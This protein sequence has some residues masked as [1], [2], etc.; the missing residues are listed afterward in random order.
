VQN[1]PFRIR[2]S[3]WLLPEE[4]N[5][6]NALLYI[7]FDGPPSGSSEIS[8]HP[9]NDAAAS[10]LISFLHVF[11]SSIIEADTYGKTGNRNRVKKT[12]S[13]LERFSAYL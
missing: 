8:I 9:V 6:D 2:S 11:T 10:S 13:L 12:G 3:V 1:F 4:R 5:K 7:H